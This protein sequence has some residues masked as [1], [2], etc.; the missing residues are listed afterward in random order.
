ME[1]TINFQ[2]IE[3]LIETLHT[4]GYEKSGF[5]M[6]FGNDTTLFTCCFSGVNAS[7]EPET[8]IFLIAGD[9]TFKPRAKKSVIVNT[10]DTEIAIT[11]VRRSPE[12]RRAKFLDGM[13][14]LAPCFDTLSWRSGAYGDKWALCTGPLPVDTI[15]MPCTPMSLVK[16]IR[17]IKRAEA[18]QDETMCSD[19]FDNPKDTVIIAGQGFM[20]IKV[21]Q[22]IA[23]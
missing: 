19:I 2:K 15:V 23:V 1:A 9:K 6:Y 14:L 10:R 20:K 16:V 8:E 17:M 22:K 12:Y 11:D 3:P 5:C 4:P 18:S 7:N 13:N 21:A